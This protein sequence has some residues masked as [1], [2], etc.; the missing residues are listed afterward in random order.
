[1]NLPGEPLIVRLELTGG[2][3]TRVDFIWF[4]LL[5]DSGV[6]GG[7]ETWGRIKALWQ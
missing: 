1:M 6:D 4:D 3:R 2:G 5:P 7:L